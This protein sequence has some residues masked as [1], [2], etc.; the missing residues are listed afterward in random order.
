M[1]AKEKKIKQAKQIAQTVKDLQTEIEAIK[2]KQTKKI[3]EMKKLGK[4]K[5]TTDASITNRIQEIENRISGVED[6]IKEIDLS[7]KENVK[8]NK[9]LTQNIQDL[10]HHEKTK[11]KNNRIEEE[12]QLKDIENI[13]NKIIEENF[14]N[15]S[16]I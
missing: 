13:F 11:P 15:L 10:G 14:P 4:Q 2:K 12:L 5:Q 3:L 16:N 1:K 8:F 9:F 7:V 6:T